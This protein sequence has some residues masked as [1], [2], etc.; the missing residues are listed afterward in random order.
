MT[1]RERFYAIFKGEKP[2]RIPLYYFGVWGET[3]ALWKQAGLPQSACEEGGPQLP[4]MDTNWEKGMWGCHGLVNATPIFEGTS[5]LIEETAD[6]VTWSHPN[7]AVVQYSKHTASIPYT[8]EHALKPT[9]ESWEQFKLAIDPYDPRRHPANQLENARKLAE[10]DRVATFMG[11]SLY[12]WIRDW[13]GVEA[14]SYF[15][16][17]EPELFGEIID[18]ITDFFIEVHRPFLRYCDFD[19]V[20]FFEDCCGSTGPLFSPTI[21]NEVY[22]RNYRKLVHFYKEEC[23]I[24]FVLLDSDGYTEPLIPCWLNSGIDILFP[25]EVGKWNANPKKIRDSF[26]EDIAIFGG[27]NKF[28]MLQPKEEIISY[29]RTL[30]P[31]VEKGRFIPIP[32]HRVP[33]EV[34]LEMMNTYIQAFHEVFNN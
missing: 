2:D 16:Y 18:Y 25:L 15:M 8:H 27:V 31:E 28:I 4:G 9:R 5:K 30:K 12:G 3:E 13:M 17:D 33:P 22:D 11:G 26:G 23:G 6:Y 7:G 21:Y 19:F 34:S 32:D 10:R 29:L 24:P 1:E 20:Y 14:L